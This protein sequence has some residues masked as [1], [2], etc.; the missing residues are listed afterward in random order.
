MKI[1]SLRWEMFCQLLFVG[2]KEI[3]WILPKHHISWCPVIKWHQRNPFFNQHMWAF[4]VSKF[5]QPIDKFSI[6]HSFIHSFKK[7]FIDLLPCTGQEGTNR[8]R[9]SSVLLRCSQWC[10][11]FYGSSEKEAFNSF[12]SSCKEFHGGVKIWNP[13]VFIWKTKQNK[14]NLF[15]F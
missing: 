6:I 4:F 5:G 11:P 1:K 9:I 14:I 12:W 2:Y 10:V 7:T 15:W 13:Y 8:S 3:Y